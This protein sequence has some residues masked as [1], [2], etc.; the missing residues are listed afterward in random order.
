MRQF[1]FTHVSS[2]TKSLFVVAAPLSLGLMSQ[3][4]MTVIDSLMISHLGLIALAA[5]GL[6]GFIILITNAMTVGFSTYVQ[7]Q[8][9][10]DLGTTLKQKKFT[11]LTIAILIAIVF[12]PAYS[13]LLYVYLPPALVDMHLNTQVTSA[14]IPYV[15][16]RLWAITLV[17]INFAFRGFFS[18]THYLKAYLLTTLI[19]HVANILFNYLF[20]FGNFGFPNL[21]LQGAALA[22]LLATVIASACYFFILFKLKFYPGNI[23]INNIRESL[24]G[25]LDVLIPYGLQQMFF[26]SG[27]AV[28]LWIIGLTGTENLAIAGLIFNVSLFFFLPAIGFGI[29]TAGRISHDMGAANYKSIVEW[30]QLA[31]AL[32]FVLFSLLSL[33]LI[34]FT[35]NFLQLFLDEPQLVAIAVTPMKIAAILFGLEALSLLY[36]QI[37]FAMNKGAQISAISVSLQWLLFLPMLYFLVNHLTVTLDQIWLLLATF[38]II[39]ILLYIKLWLK[40]KKVLTSKAAKYSI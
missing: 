3:N 9:A 21:G 32:V 1:N 25:I 28:T 13:G 5:I 33:P 16:L 30:A 38:R 2:Q 29:A 23:G 20:I 4:L 37:F 24:S 12:L 39:N 7:R 19:M 10:Y 15:E 31:G 22:S 18:A 40:I 34:F 17:G 35:E 27:F 6:G 8:T 14:M 11:S 26:V 36:L